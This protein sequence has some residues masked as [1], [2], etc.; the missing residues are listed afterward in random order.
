MI[1]VRRNKE[2]GRCVEVMI[3]WTARKRENDAS[4]E[5]GC[6]LVPE[7]VMNACRELYEES[8]NKWAD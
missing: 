5:R 8:V 3:G 6:E 1:D 2:K 7:D 4:D